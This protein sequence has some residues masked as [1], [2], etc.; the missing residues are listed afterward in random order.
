VTVGGSR[1]HGGIF[2]ENA[3]AGA[4]ASYLRRGLGAEPLTLGARRPESALKG[5]NRGVDGALRLRG[6]SLGLR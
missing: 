6:C 4:G 5:C 1:S 2:E 3:L